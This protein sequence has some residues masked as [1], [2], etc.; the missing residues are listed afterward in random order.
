M[1]KESGA[2]ILGSHAAAVVG[3]TQEGHAAVADLNG[4]LGSAGV[5]GVFQQFLYNGSG[6]L[7]HLT[8][9][10]QVGNMGG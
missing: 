2:G 3:D 9:G 4:D 1:A 8:G 10:D 6:A 7:Y 5:N